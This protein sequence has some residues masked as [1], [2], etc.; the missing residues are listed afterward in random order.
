MGI[1]MNL[2][3]L[4]GLSKSEASRMLRYAVTLSCHSAKNKK[5][6]RRNNCQVPPTRHKKPVHDSD[7]DNS[8]EEEF[9][10]VV[11]DYG[12]LG[13]DDL[14]VDSGGDSGGNIG[15]SGNNRGDSGEDLEDDE[16]SNIS[17]YDSEED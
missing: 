10:E 17:L 4:T 9:Q 11:N 15:N 13:T 5:S 2:L 8:E 12:G 6:G 14:E 7:K 16:P 3:R 1:Q